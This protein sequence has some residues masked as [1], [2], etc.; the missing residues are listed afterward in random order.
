MFQTNS[1]V[2]PEFLANSSVLAGTSLALWKKIAD[3]DNETG[4][5]NVSVSGIVVQSKIIQMAT[6]L[7]GKSR[8]VC[9]IIV[10]F[11][12]VSSVFPQM[13]LCF[14]LGCCCPSNVAAIFRSESDESPKE[15]GCCCCQKKSKQ[16]KSDDSKQQSTVICSSSNCCGSNPNHHGCCC[17]EKTQKQ[18]QLLKVALTWLA[19]PFQQVMIPSFETLA[20]SYDV[21]SLDWFTFCKPPPLRLHLLLL[22]LLN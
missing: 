10:V 19:D 20:V 5:Y 15:A 6:L 16:E 9:W 14:C 3:N 4:H 18:V 22:V 12:M 11:M 13:G 17:S 2:F 7:L 21:F 1:D 8:L